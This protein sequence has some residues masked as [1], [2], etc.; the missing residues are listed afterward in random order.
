MYTH[1]THFS[2]PLPLPQATTSNLVFIFVVLYIYES[3]LL[4][5]TERR[6]YS[7]FVFLRLTY[8]T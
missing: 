3:F 6:D 1:F 7:E 2:H 8:F 4:D 5:S